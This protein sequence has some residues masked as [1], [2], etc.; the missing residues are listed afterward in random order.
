LAFTVP[1]IVGGVFVGAQ[2]LQSYGFSLF[3][4]APFSLGMISVLLF[5][6]S[7]PQPFWACL[8]VA[9]LTSMATVYAMLLVGLEGAGCLIM[10]APIAFPVVILGAV[11]GYAIQTRTWLTGETPV[12]TLALLITLPTLMAAEAVNEPEPA[13]R[14]INTEVIINASPAR[15]W[16]YVIAF[17]PLP[18]PE[19]WLFQTGIAYPQRAE[20]RGTGVGAIRHCIFSTGTFVEPIEVWDAPRRLCFQVTDQP[21]PMREWS[22]Y[23]IHPAH[24]DHYLVS[25]RGRFLLEAL[26]DGRTRLIGTTWYSNR[27]WP[28]AYWQLWSD[29]I[30]H[31]IHRRVL[32]HIQTLAEANVE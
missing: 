2:V 32:A 26:P 29:Y 4:G 24:L 7:R 14:A 22:P 16:D 12:L 9:T 13:V 19:D 15:V 5:G 21:E 31:R 3:L 27:M 28:A 20:I 1:C 23:H 8:V 30:I 25:R 11:V 6:F 17:P 18:E 10:A